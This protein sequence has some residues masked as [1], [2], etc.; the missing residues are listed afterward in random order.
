MTAAVTT[1][2]AQARTSCCRLDPV[3]CA[4]VDTQRPIGGVVEDVL[5]SRL[6]SHLGP[7]LI[8]SGGRI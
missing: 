6:E 3:Y 7:R 1:V 8:H 4:D 2:L 5:E